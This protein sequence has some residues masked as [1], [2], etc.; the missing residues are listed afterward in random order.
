MMVGFVLLG[1]QPV[2]VKALA[3]LGWSAPSVVT[4]RFAF[5]LICIVAICWARGRGLRTGN[6]RV[7][8][9]RG[10][11]GGVAVLLYFL[12]IQLAGA[13]PGTVLNYT[14]PIWS[15]VM[16]VAFLGARPRWTF[17]V[18]L[19]AAVAGVWLI[20]NP[21]W[22]EQAGWGALAGLCS[23]MLAGAAV[24]C[25]KKL[26]ETDES[27]TIIASFSVV[28]LVLAA[29]LAF[30]QAFPPAVSSASGPQL[31]SDWTLP[32]FLAVGVL[33]FLGHIYFTRGYR[34]T[35]VPL[36]T[37][38]SLT[39]PVIAA[40]SGALV[41]GEEIGWR[42]VVG[43]ALVLAACL[44]IGRQTAA[45]PSAEPLPEAPSQGLARANAA[46]R[47]GAPELLAGEEAPGEG[48]P[49]AEPPASVG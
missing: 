14:Y 3:S 43:G 25:I 20:I 10:I 47:S 23:G 22:D 17:W 30:W 35:S 37:V 29:P 36:G 48:E 24:L 13:G 7:L 32:A 34:G 19:G 21:R 1:L 18:L 38:L 31:S 4:A 5:S 6:P 49:T 41:F 39:V 16:A 44:G 8:L 40:A 12:A 11:L 33:A 9:W 42:F 27:L 26:R 46:V 45:A 2:P 15:N 28:G